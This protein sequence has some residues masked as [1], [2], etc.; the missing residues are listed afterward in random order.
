[1]SYKLTPEPGTHPEI[2]ELLFDR[3]VI[4]CTLKFEP[5][6]EKLRKIEQIH[7]AGAGINLDFNIK[8]NNQNYSANLTTKGLE[9]ATISIDQGSSIQEYFESDKTDIHGNPVVLETLRTEVIEEIARAG[10]KELVNLENKI[11]SHQNRL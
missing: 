7:Y 3:Y 9:N 5:S 6:N 11:F 4:L 8:V 1:M 2:N 10:E